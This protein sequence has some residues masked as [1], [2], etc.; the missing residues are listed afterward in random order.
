ME[1][2]NLYPDEMSGDDAPAVEDLEEENE[3]ETEW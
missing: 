3:V 2:T 1:E